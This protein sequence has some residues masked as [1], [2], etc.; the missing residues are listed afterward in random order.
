MDSVL[1][2]APCGF[3]SFRDDGTIISVNHTLKE[4]LG[5]Q[6]ESLEGRNIETI[7]TVASRIFYNTHFFPL[8]RLHSKA[9]EIF[10][11]LLAKD[12]KD[13]PVLTNAVRKLE[14]GLHE[15]HCIFIP[16]HQRKRFEEEILSA[17]KV[18]E[19]TLK[20]NEGL[21]SLTENLETH[22]RELDKQLSKLVAINEDL[23]QLNRVISHDFQ[24]PIRKIQIFT[25]ILSRS[26][27]G[28]ATAKTKN[29][30]S[31]IRRASGRLRQLISVLEHYVS[32][33]TNKKV[34]Q[35]DLN[36]V[37]NDAKEKAASQKQFND[38]S[39]FNEG[40]PVVDGYPE[41]LE[42]LFYHLI[43]NAI[44]Y[45]EPARKL[46]LNVKSVITQENIFRSIKNRYKYTDHVKITLSDNGIG[47]DNDYK[48]YVFD[49]L[50]KMDTHTKGI[51][52]GLPLSKKI[53]DNHSGIINVQ[54]ERGHGTEFNILLPMKMD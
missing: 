1:N 2:Y 8:I 16:I 3:L 54:S 34:V 39:F 15:N 45:R 37:L 28:S 53:V 19:D 51:G 36:R 46:I 21:V 24:E 52:L 35:V 40:L 31:K 49:L 7:L 33:D 4:I 50:K 11:S 5:Y 47:F 44:D 38:F 25:D 41:Q 20:K 22:S 42:L 48:D 23:V 27:E 9:D 32:I 43:S 18:A 29:A 13:I 26:A 12:K 14:N 17:R 10:F 30:L 6:D